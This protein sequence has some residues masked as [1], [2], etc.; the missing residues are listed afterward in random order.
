M[1][2]LSMMLKK[3]LV[4]NVQATGEEYER[5]N[6]DDIDWIPGFENSVKALT[7]VSPKM[8]AADLQVQYS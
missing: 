4:I 5:K 1:I 2:R 3:Q 6:I 8:D 7:S